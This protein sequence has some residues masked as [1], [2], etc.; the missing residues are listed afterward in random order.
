MK[1]RIR[2]IGLLMLLSIIG[3]L[4]SF[5]DL[6]STSH[7]CY[8]MS[9]NAI[10]F[11]F[12]VP[13]GTSPNIGRVRVY[14]N[15]G[16]SSSGLSY[17]T[18]S[19]DPQG[20]GL[21]YGPFFVTGYSTAHDVAS[22]NGYKVSLHNEGANSYQLEII[23]L[24]DGSGYWDSSD[25]ALSPAYWEITVTGMGTTDPYDLNLTQIRAYPVSEPNAA[26]YIT[27]TPSGLQFTW[28]SACNQKPLLDGINPPTPSTMMPLM[29]EDF[30]ADNPRDVDGNLQSYLWNFGGATTDGLLTETKPDNTKFPK[31]YVA[32]GSYTVTL[33]LR[34]TNGALSDSDPVTAAVDD[35]ASLTVETNQRPLVSGINAP[36]STTTAL[37]VQ[38]SAN[39]PTEPTPDGDPDGDSVAD[40]V[41]DFA[42]ETADG[43]STE[44]RHDKAQFTKTYTTD[45]DKTVTL[46]VV[47]DKGLSSDSDTAT[48]AADPIE[49]SVN[50]NRQ[51]IVGI[52]PNAVFPSSITKSGTDL[53][54][55]VPVLLSLS[56]EVVD[57][58][59]TISQYTWDLDGVGGYETTDEPPF[60]TQTKGYN[61]IGVNAIRLIGR[62]SYTIASVPAVNTVYV[63]PDENMHFARAVGVPYDAQKSPTVDGKLLSGVPDSVD[64][65]YGENGWRGAYEQVYGSSVA[66][67]DFVFQ[68]IRD[69]AANILYFSLEVRW[70]DVLNSDDE[71]ILGIRGDSSDPLA[72][73]TATDRLIRID[74][75]AA[76][77]GTA[78][79]SGIRVY[80]RAGAAI[81]DGWSTSASTNPPGLVCAKQ[82]L[83]G[84]TWTIEIAVPMD[85][86]SGWE[87]IDSQFLFFFSI[88]RTISSAV[89]TPDY[90]RW[91]TALDLAPTV[92]FFIDDTLDPGYS[93]AKTR[94]NPLWWGMVDLST[95]LACNGLA[96]SSSSYVGSIPVDTVANPGYD[97]AA[98]AES[99][100][101]TSSIQYTDPTVS[102][103]NAY[104][105]ILVARVKNDTHFQ[106]IDA[107]GD[108]RT[109]MLRVPNVSVSFKIAN[110]GIPPDFPGTSYWQDI[111]G[112]PTTTKTVQRDPATEPTGYS[113]TGDPHY[114]PFHVEWPLSA[115]EI[116]RYTTDTDDGD[117]TGERHQCIYVEILASANDGSDPDSIQN[118]RI[119]TKS[120]HRNMNFDA[121]NAAEG[122]IHKADISAIGYG[123]PLTGEPN[124]KFLLRIFTR[125][126]E[127]NLN[128]KKIIA[129]L[130]GSQKEPGE[131]SGSIPAGM[132]AALYNDLMGQ[133]DILLRYV[134]EKKKVV[135]YIEYIVKGFL[136]TGK[137]AVSDGRTLDIVRSIGSYGHLVR[138][139]GRVEDWEFSITG[140]G[141][142][143]LNRNTYLLEIPQ[144]QTKRVFDNVK[145]LEPPKW[146]ILVGSGAAIPL[147]ALAQEYSTGFNAIGG[148][149]YHAIPELSVDLLFGCNF[150]PARTPPL[151][152]ARLLSL[153]LNAR[154]HAPLS[155]IG[156]LYAGGGPGAYAVPGLSS[157]LAGANGGAG[158]ELRL[159]HKLMIE[160]GAEYHHVFGSNTQYVHGHVGM[161]L[162][163]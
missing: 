153:S 13:T 139:E 132:S 128:D 75:S 15:I 74:P 127:V 11:R 152:D 160:A 55:K 41:W 144:E 61:S 69:N 107:S 103:S 21:L 9:V 97:A 33:Q 12:T 121:Q 18:V 45:G 115:P 136:Y 78:G 101:L 46:R 116:E 143:R 95:S 145:A 27:P 147:N 118:P 88:Q 134:S 155:N 35:P 161:V 104:T 84:N 94:L 142:T 157:F 19:I 110:W 119:V 81:A 82:P 106:E 98:L 87:A 80:R 63:L 51:P 151:A 89:V 100:T 7:S 148:I 135:S 29:L 111:P 92:D 72:A 154:C 40:Y 23:N 39:M 68:G 124:Q 6:P 28:T 67:G 93:W 162:R 60:T 8:S 77:T 86:A 96:L 122:F 54:G 156:F 17:G 140:Q 71:I 109:K 108:I 99:G 36:L 5:A 47:D 70:D 16:N 137:T 130:G 73:N 22:P 62:D 149:G 10:S 91:P 34:D 56:P 64:P 66:G 158:I 113:T 3:S 31:T 48:P 57:N 14:F 138:H 30:E 76:S 43:L 42:G 58:D 2:M 26:N 79:S 112:S 50:P 125:T 102:L 1:N 38:F 37:E 120:V 117:T 25:A 4:D 159:A 90:G 105:N 150:L 32:D 52:A 126:W 133:R 49:Q 24:V 53:F 20:S 131:R 114:E 123:M 163:F 141:I 59:D 129:A 83:A 146:S 44:T 85:A 65:N